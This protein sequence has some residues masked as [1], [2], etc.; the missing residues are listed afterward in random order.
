VNAFMS[1]STASPSAAAGGSVRAS[2]LT[3]RSRPYN[4]RPAFM[5]SVMA[6]E[7]MN[8]ASPGPSSAV[9]AW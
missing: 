3:S 7:A 6:S 1:A 5:A 4:P 8:T 9:T 2:T